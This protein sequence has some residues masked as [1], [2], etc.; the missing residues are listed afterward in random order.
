MRFLHAL[1]TIVLVLFFVSMV[2]MRLT[3]G[4][5]EVAGEK[6]DRFMGVTATEV[7]AAADD[8][9]EATD[10]VVK[11]IADGPDDEN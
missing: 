11:D 3:Y 4:S 8:V 6:M 1:L 10:T 2:A 9:A 5:F 7:G